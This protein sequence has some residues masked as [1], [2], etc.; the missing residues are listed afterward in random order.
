MNKKM[1]GA[2]LGGLAFTAVNVARAEEPKKTEKK[3]DKKTD[4]KHDEKGGEKSCGGDKGC[5]GDKK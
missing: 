5:G 1:L 4:K 3:A 2:I